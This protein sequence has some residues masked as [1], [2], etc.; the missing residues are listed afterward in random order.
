MFPTCSCDFITVIRTPLV[1]R[2]RYLQ[3]VSPP[4]ALRCLFFS[5]RLLI[6]R[7]TAG[8]TDVGLVSAPLVPSSGRDLQGGGQRSLVP[9]W[10]LAVCVSV[11]VQTP[12]IRGGVKS[13]SET[14]DFIG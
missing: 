8:R 5:V 12:P 1:V 9:L 4:V 3:H 13:L 11:G 6:G 14:C 10:T 7:R 2:S